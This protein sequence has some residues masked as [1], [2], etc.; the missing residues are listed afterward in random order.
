MDLKYVTSEQVLEVTYEQEIRRFVVTSPPSQQPENLEAK[1]DALA[2]VPTLQ[3]LI[4]G[5]DTSV[6]LVGG[7]A[8][9]VV[10]PNSLVLL[11]LL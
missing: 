5:W 6:V 1:F 11:S 7:G 2:L 8:D 10:N 9:E 3:I 4:V